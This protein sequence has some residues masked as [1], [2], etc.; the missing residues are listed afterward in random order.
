MFYGFK[1]L[2]DL[3]TAPMS[4]AAVS[5][6]ESEL[7]SFI[8][9]PLIKNLYDL[10]CALLVI[11]L[12]FLGFLVSYNLAAFLNWIAITLKLKPIPYPVGCPQIDSPN[13]SVNNPFGDAKIGIVFA[14]GGAKGAFQAG[15]MRA[16]YHYLYDCN[17]LEKVNVI[18]GTSIGSWNA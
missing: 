7:P 17:A 15:A 11:I 6:V 4:R 8:A 16:I 18:S 2:K 14:G 3:L 5:F 12:F 9:N 10:L 13:P 1:Y